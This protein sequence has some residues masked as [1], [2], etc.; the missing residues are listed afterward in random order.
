M[1][2]NK[3]YTLPVEAEGDDIV[4][5]FPDALMESLQWS[6]GDQVTWTEN[7][8]GSWTLSKVKNEQVG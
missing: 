7:N 5:T 3:S 4:L 8:D 1:E 6:V 2:I